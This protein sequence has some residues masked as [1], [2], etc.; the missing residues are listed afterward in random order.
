MQEGDKDYR[1]CA[2]KNLPQRPDN[3]KQIAADKLRV[4]TDCAFIKPKLHMSSY[5]GIRPN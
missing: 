2:H 1:T 5:D 4:I 3:V